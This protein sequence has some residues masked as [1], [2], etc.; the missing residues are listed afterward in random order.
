MKGLLTSFVLVFYATSPMLAQQA[1]T[2]AAY[3]MARDAQ[4]RAIENQVDWDKATK[5]TRL[6]DPV[7]GISEIPDISTIKEGWVGDLSGLSA[8]VVEIVSPNEMLVGVGKSHVVWLMDYPTKEFTSNQSV[9]LVGP[10]KAGPTK[11]YESIN[12]SNRTVRTFRLVNG[13]ELRKYIDQTEANR[14]QRDLEESETR[15]REQIAK[16][17]RGIIWVSQSPEDPSGM[18]VRRRKKYREEIEQV[19]RYVK[20]SKITAGLAFPMTYDAKKKRIEF[21][22]EKSR[23][24]AQDRLKTLLADIPK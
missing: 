13:D 11:S 21:D 17:I 12:G 4:N 1:G 18:D 19:G 23:T 7:R 10:I 6:K 24:I 20:A 15:I 14:K 8:Q 22:S 5:I 16:A 2:A 9:R 3:N